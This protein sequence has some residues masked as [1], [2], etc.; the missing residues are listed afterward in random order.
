V[1]ANG[2]ELSEETMIGKKEETV[3]KKYAGDGTDKQ[4]WDV[5]IKD[6]RHPWPDESVTGINLNQMIIDYL[7][8][9]K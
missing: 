3:F 5:F 9:Y 6:G 1:K 4:V 7:N 8:C 2:L